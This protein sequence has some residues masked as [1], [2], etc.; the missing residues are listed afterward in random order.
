MRE[1][2]GG[3]EEV[4]LMKDCPLWEMGKLKPKPVPN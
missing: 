3:L 1:E 4:F 2:K